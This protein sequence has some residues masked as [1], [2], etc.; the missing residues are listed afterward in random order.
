MKKIKIILRFFFRPPYRLIKSI[1]RDIYIHRESSRLANI[2]KREKK[3]LYF[4]ITEHS[5][6]GDLAQYYC[7]QRWINSNYPDTPSYE[8]EATIIVDKR[9]R[10]LKQLENV[11]GDTDIIIFQS[12]YT[13][14]DLGGV[15][16]EMHRLVLDRFPNANVLMMPQTIFFKEEKNRM[17]TAQSLNRGK[18]HLFLSRDRISYEQAL[19]MF[20][21]I[22]NALFPDIVTTLIGYY[23]FDN[24]RDGVLICRRNDG[25]KYY[26]E[27]KII[28]L[29]KNLEK[30]TNVYI[31]DTTINDSYKKIR[32]NLKPYIE[33][34]IEE[35][36]KYKVIITDRY[37]GTI[38][39]LAANTP[40]IVIQTND[41]KVVTGLD[42]FKGVY[43]EHAMF[44]NSLEDALALA[45]KTL[46]ANINFKLD[47]YY[48]DKYSKE[49]KPL[50]EKVMLNN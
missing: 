31:S 6:L 2:S 9:F 40:V 3:I 32:K 7:I 13:T 45:K 30:I 41:H 46:D 17:R 10:F 49:L 22:T 24:E 38:F 18:H 25:E 34:I 48:D 5:N 44:A 37:H 29:K 33:S 42:W 16:D 11:L 50:L 47:P 27:D 19:I 35:Y 4:G 8:F 36:S 12:G 21:D 23:S 28:E 14:Q 26:D 15:H 43:D 20:P 1:I 39:A